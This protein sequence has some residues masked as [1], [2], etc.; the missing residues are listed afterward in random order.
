MLEARIGFY[1]ASAGT[2]VSSS[3]RDWRSNFI[4]IDG[5]KGGSVESSPSG[6]NQKDRLLKL[7]AIQIFAASTFF[8]DVRNL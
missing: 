2:E 6:V 5:N 8:L 3:Q 1:G 7:G 4:I